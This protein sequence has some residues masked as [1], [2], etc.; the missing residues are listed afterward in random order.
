L[1]PNQPGDTM[2]TE[3][4]V[5]NSSLS[6]L[7]GVVLQ[8]RVPDEVDTFDDSLI[9]GGGTCS[10]FGCG[11]SEQVTWTIGTLAAGAEVTVS[12]LPVV[13]N[14]SGLVDGQLI[15]VDGSVTEDGKRQTTAAYTV[16]IGP[17]ADADFDGMPDNYELSNG[18]DPN[19]PEDAD[20]DADSDG[21]TNLEEFIAGTLPHNTDT[22]GDNVQDGLDAFPLDPN[23]WLDTDGDGTGNNTDSDDDGDGM[24]DDYEIANGLDPLNAADAAA[25]ADGDGFS[26][27]EEFLAGTDPQDANDFPDINDVPISIFI[28]LGEEEE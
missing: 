9:T 24:P 16:I 10:L 21:L 6:T 23:E 20:E 25:D 13:S 1:A 15:T 18:F 14:S 11:F 3:L 5:S 26:N 7:F 12:M 28:L 27:L 17:F 8:A 19:N 2:T 4:T 22:D